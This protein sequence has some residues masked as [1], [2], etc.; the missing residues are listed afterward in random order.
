[1]IA[2]FIFS[3][4]VR[5]RRDLACTAILKSEIVKMFTELYLKGFANSVL[6][7]NY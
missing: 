5:F 7:L 3:K 6:L 2:E 4:S 1:M